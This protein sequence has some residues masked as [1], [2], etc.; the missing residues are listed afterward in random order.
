MK[1]QN[2]GEHPLFTQTSWLCQQIGVEQKEETD[3]TNLG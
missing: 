3:F 1:Y 2:K